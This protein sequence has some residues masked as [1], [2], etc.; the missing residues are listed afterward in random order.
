MANEPDNRPDGSTPEPF[1]SG[2]TLAPGHTLRTYRV[3]RVVGEGGFGIVYLAFDLSLERRVAVKEYLPSAIA[4]RASD[5]RTVAIQSPAHVPTFAA[6]LKS[7]VNEARLLAR[8]DHPALV[9][10]HQFWEDNGTAYMAMPFYEGPTLKA[11][12]R[13]LGRPPTDAEVRAWLDP[14]MDALD[15]LHAENCYHRDIAPDNILVTPAGPLLL[16]FGAA[17]R[18]IGDMTHA[19]TAVLK[20]GFAPI[21]QYGDM[22]GRGQGP[23]TD[24]YALASTLYAAIGGVRPAPSVER[25]MH[26]RMKPLAQ[27]AAG[28]FEPAFLAT[29]DRA[30]AIRP[31]DRPQTIGEF[32]ALLYSPSAAGAAT[33]ATPGGHAVADGGV[34]IG[35]DFAAAAAPAPPRPRSRRSYAPA[36]GLV[37]PQADAAPH[38]PAAD[39]GRRRLWSAIGAGAALALGFGAYRLWSHL[40]SRRQ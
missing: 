27:L 36:R 34:D 9:K 40:G 19:L 17:R 33:A 23:W 11:A 20:P 26:D 38:P 14:L 32:R 29:V 12:L 39:R 4:A 35:L 7:F 24:I 18:V 37:D 10:V 30:L 25:L 5:G 13:S 8:F 1:G 2:H 21:E 15:V 22:P 6:G 16:D 3:E 28:R 31:E